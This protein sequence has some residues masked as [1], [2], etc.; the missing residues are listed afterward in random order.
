MLNLNGTV[1]VSVVILGVFLVFV[2]NRGNF[3]TTDV[4]ENQ[5]IAGNH[6]S[7]SNKR[8]RSETYDLSLTEIM[9]R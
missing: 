2:D 6:F 7:L 3:G 1:R 8:L 5:S 4:Y 9:L